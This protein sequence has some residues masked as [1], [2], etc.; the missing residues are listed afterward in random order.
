MNEAI[1]D[2][3][4]IDVAGLPAP[5]VIA[6]EAVVAT[7]R[8]EL[9]PRSPRDRQPVKLPSWPGT[10]VGELTREEIYGDLD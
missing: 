3:M 10:V 2:H 4:T 9:Q 1:H 6:L 8:Q 7:L 5:V